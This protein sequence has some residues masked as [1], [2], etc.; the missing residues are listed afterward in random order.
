MDQSRRQHNTKLLL[1]L[2]LLAMAYSAWLYKL[3]TITGQNLLDGS[4]GVLLGLYICS[5]QAANAVDF[6]FF[7]RAVLGPA[8]SK[9]SRLSWPALNALVLLVG[10]LLIVIG[11]SRLVGPVA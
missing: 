7:R 5:H 3:D 6:L 10:W 11:T 9:L 8:P 2:I 4:L 1:G